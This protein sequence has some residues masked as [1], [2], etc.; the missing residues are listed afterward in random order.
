MDKESSGGRVRETDTERDARDMHMEKDDPVPPSDSN[1]H[2]CP[3][4]LGQ[5]PSG[6]RQGEVVEMES[7]L[8]GRMDS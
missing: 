4:V 5:R 6:G 7:H 8:E 3:S 2:R 1:L